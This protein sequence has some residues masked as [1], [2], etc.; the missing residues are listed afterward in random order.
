MR[1]ALFRL[2][3]LSL[4]AL[5]GAATAH[6]Q[7][8]PH[9]NIKWPTCTGS[10]VLYNI[11]TNTC[12]ANGTGNGV[13]IEATSPVLVNGASGPVSSGIADISCPTCGNNLATFYQPADPTTQYALVFA[14]SCSVT[15]ATRAS[16]TNSSGVGLAIDHSINWTD[17]TLPSY[18]NPAN[19][20][21][22][23]AFAISAANFSNYS[24]YGFSITGTGGGSLG[25]CSNGLNSAST[26]YFRPVPENVYPLGQ[27]TCP[28]T[29][30]P[31]N[32]STIQL[33]E[34][35][36]NVGSGEVI[37]PLIGLEVHYT[38]TPP[39]ANNS[40]LIQPPLSYSAVNNTLGISPAWPN[41][42]Y[43]TA[44][45]GLP[46]ANGLPFASFASDG[47]T[48]TDCSTGGGSD[49]VLCYND[50]S[51][52][53]GYAI[54]G[55]GSSPLTTKGDLYTYSTTNARLPVGTDTY[56]L[57]AD[58]T[59]ATGIKWTAPAASGVSSITATSPLR[60][61]ATSGSPQTG[62][63]TVDCPT[64]GGGGGITSGT[65]LAAGIVGTSSN[66]GW[67]N[68]TFAMMI[69]GNQ[70]TQLAT[71][72][73]VRVQAIG[74][75]GISINSAYV[76]ATNHYGLTTLTSP[77]PVQITWNGGSASYAVAFS[78]ASATAPFELVSDAVTF[79]VSSIY[80]IWVFLYL[81]SDGT[82]YNSAINLWG[83]GANCGGM[84]ETHGS[85]NGI[86]S[87][88]GGTSTGG[89]ISGCS[90]PI[91]ITSIEAN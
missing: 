35:S 5:A 38:G 43:A 1:S 76:F 68:Y 84:N 49:L 74:G 46:L 48:S 78:G 12:V 55:S 59:Q 2:W 89:A 50:G 16:C 21:A 57:T 52:Y 8:N 11:V 51:T 26:T 9:T 91:L 85:G 28:Y 58:S 71:A 47:A 34:S 73:K 63:V 36:S 30:L 75:T 25:V 32:F 15:D 45:A 69:H 61:N 6:G 67:A 60:A 20:T 83:S 44:V 87:S 29:G 72:F 79:P 10:A 82:G 37:I 80:D 23:Y 54:G 62:A 90:T 14:H 88:S 7:I 64:C 56:V 77:A 42:E 13:Q 31:T 33:R 22:M 81:D 65:P 4:I 66:S 3:F 17:Y 39:P 27:V 24:I 19:I 86:P 53:T 41:L 70:L 18:I 40:L